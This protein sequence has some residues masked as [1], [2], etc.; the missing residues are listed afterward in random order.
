MG[1]LPFLSQLSKLDEMVEIQWGFVA[2]CFLLV[3]RQYKLVQSLTIIRQDTLFPI[4]SYK[5]VDHLFPI[6]LVH[7]DV[8]MAQVYGESLTHVLVYTRQA[9][10]PCWAQWVVR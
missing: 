9:T 6:Q 10:G 4:V 5:L 3:S 7:D 2:V 1:F 8:S